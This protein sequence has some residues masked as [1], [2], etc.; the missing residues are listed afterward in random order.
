M[1][2]VHLY[3]SN[4]Q[5]EIFNTNFN[6]IHMMGVGT[7][8]SLK[9]KKSLQADNLHETWWHYDK[10]NNREGHAP[11]LC[12]AEVPRVVRSTGAE[13]KMVVGVGGEKNGELLFAFY[14]FGFAGKVPV[15][16]TGQLGGSLFSTWVSGRELRPLG[17]P[18]YHWASSKTRELVLN[19]HSSSLG[20]WNSPGGES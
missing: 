18:L 8:L 7:T 5:L 15:G 19:W 1:S 17:C 2:I 16:V 11:R 6:K 4:E 9:G 10:W 20:R 13:S 14:F 12:L 3:F